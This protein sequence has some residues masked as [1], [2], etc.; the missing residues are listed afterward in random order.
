M[1]LFKL[2][3]ANNDAGAVW[4]PKMTFHFGSLNFVIDSK[5]AMGEP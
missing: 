4:A 2:S 3:M 1:K 5:G